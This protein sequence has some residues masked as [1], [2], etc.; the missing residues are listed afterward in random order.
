M[1]EEEWRVRCIRCQIEKTYR[2]FYAND[3][4][5]T[6]CRAC[7]RYMRVGRL[8]KAA[9]MNEQRASVTRNALDIE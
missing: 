5:K 6:I 3:P 9:R 4:D 8:L 2:A 1:E 7:L